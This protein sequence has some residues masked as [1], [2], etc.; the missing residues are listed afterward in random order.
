M[1]LA[2]VFWLSG[3]LFTYGFNMKMFEEHECTFKTKAL[4]AF[5]VHLWLAWPLLLGDGLRRVLDK[6]FK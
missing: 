5:S 4:F 2:G 6:E 1:Y 3:I